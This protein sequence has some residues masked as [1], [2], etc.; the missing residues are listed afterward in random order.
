MW[1]TDLCKNAGEHFHFKVSAVSVSLSALLP[2][3]IFCGKA[4]KSYWHSKCVFLLLTSGICG[5][6]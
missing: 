1:R 4:T 2:Y 3:V 6:A 5:L